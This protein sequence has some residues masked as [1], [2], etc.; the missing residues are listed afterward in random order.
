MSLQ[1]RVVH[2]RTGKGTLTNHSEIKKEKKEQRGRH[3]TGSH[4]AASEDKA[5]PF[6]GLLFTS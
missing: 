6:F 3:V 1:P 4:Q 5:E 2:N